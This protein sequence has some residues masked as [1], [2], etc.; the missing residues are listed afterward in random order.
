LI[1]DSNSWA[2]GRLDLGAVR[3]IDRHSCRQSASGRQANHSFGA[4]ERQVF[5]GQNVFDDFQGIE[6]DQGVVF[7][8]M[9]RVH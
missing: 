6:R 2:A 9:G 1:S 5:S 3:P 4:V 8:G 7:F